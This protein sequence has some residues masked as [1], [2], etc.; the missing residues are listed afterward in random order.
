MKFIKKSIYY[1]LVCFIIICLTSCE[2][3]RTKMVVDGMSPILEKMKI[4][5]NKNNDFELVRDSMPASIIQLEGFVEV[6]PNNTD[7]LIRTSEA[8][9]SYAFSFIEDV[10]KQ[11]ALKLY[12]KARQLALRA[13]TCHKSFIIGKGQTNDA[14]ISSLN[15]FNAY[16]VPALFYLCGSWMQMIALNPHSQTLSIELSQIEA[17]LDKILSLNENYNYGAVHALFGG[18]FA[19]RLPEL[20]GKPDQAKF[21]FEEAMEIS[22]SKYLLWHYLY[23][24]YYAVQIKDKDL[25]VSTLNG[26]INAPD[27][28]LKEAVLPNQIAKHKAKYLLA[29]MNQYF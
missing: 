14:F 15:A 22:D 5:M 10:D 12:T 6:S 18:F 16:Y 23:A 24:K 11:R 27:T 25:F 19:S 2:S 9:Y 20:G 8:Y 17:I 13:L 21:H 4:S 28:I 26:I 29:N 3:V 7:L 1:I